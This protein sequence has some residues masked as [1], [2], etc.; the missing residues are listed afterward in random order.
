MA[1]DSEEQALVDAQLTSA[2]TYEAA[3]SALEPYLTPTE[4]GRYSF[5]DADLSLLG[6]DPAMVQDL[7][8]SL[9]DLNSSLVN[10][11]IALSDVEMG[12]GHG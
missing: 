1:D 11:A 8:A 3:I 2:A 12:S 9:D 7:V 6:V 5:G 10:Q 4:D